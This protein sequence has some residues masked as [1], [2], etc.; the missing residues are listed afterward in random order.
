MAER[1]GG[2]AF[3]A[4]DEDALAHVFATIDALEKSPVEGTVR[5]RYDE[6]YAP[7]VG[8]AL[9]ILVVERLLASGRLR[10]IP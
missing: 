1:G 7:W 2:R 10:R 8:L 3:E 5:T 4:A 6:R 9:T